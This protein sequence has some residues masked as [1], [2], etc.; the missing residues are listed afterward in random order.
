MTYTEEL[1]VKLKPKQK[2]ML[3]EMADKSG[4]SMAQILRDGMY[5]EIAALRVEL[6]HKSQ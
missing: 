3:Q 6:R 1:L 5:R 2:Q 4:K